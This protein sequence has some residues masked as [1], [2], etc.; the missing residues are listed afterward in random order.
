MYSFL[1]GTVKLNVWDMDFVQF[2]SE[3]S[4]REK[5][6]IE[7]IWT[8]SFY[9]GCQHWQGDLKEK[10]ETLEILQASVLRV[11]FNSLWVLTK[12]NK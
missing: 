6:I 10:Q 2:F 9:F 5:E 8:N 12:I 4:H 7:F 1:K 11:M 3:Y